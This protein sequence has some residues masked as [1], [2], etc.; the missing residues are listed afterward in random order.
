MLQTFRAPM[1]ATV[2]DSSGEPITIV[3]LNEHSINYLLTTYI[4][5]QPLVLLSAFVREASVDSEL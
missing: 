3:L 4:Y 2:M 1:A 5:I